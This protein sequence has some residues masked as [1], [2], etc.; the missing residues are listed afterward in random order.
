MISRLT[1]QII[2]FMHEQPKLPRKKFKKLKQILLRMKNVI[3][4]NCAKNNS[5]LK[6]DIFCLILRKLKKILVLVPNIY[7]NNL[8]SE[9]LRAFEITTYCIRLVK[10]EH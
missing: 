8:R 2:S 10:N 5:F 3:D 1:C 6:F 7:I 4:L 9:D